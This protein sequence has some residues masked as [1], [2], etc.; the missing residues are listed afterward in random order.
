MQMNICIFL[1]LGAFLIFETKSKFY[2]K[3]AIWPVLQ[4][5]LEVWEVLQKS[6]KQF[7]TAC[8]SAAN[9]ALKRKANKYFSLAFRLTFF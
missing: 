3:S 1:L 4:S 2:I 7:F 8:F 5:I 6:K 9:L